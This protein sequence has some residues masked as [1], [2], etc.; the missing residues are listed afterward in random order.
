MNLAHDILQA[1]DERTVKIIKDLL[2]T[3]DTQVVDLGVHGWFHLFT[4]L[5]TTP[6][7]VNKKI[8]SPTRRPR[9]ARYP[10]R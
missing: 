7:P 3:G 6:K 5:K 2:K 10:S 4:A 8:I 1:L 9:P